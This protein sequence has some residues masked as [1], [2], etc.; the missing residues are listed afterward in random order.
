MRY[1]PRPVM[2]PNGHTDSGVKLEG[3]PLWHGLYAR[4]GKP[5]NLNHLTGSVWVSPSKVFLVGRKLLG[6]FG[7]GYRRAFLG[8]LVSGPYEETVFSKTGDDVPADVSRLVVAARLVLDAGHVGEEF[9][10]LDAAAEA[11]AAR[12][13]WDDEP[14]D[15]AGHVTASNADASQAPGSAKDQ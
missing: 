10:E 1:Q 3:R 8:V 6:M 14:D 9:A 7:V 15:G 11:F 12:V 13:L 2:A 5:R 4:F